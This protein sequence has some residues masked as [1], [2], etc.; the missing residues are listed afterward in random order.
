MNPTELRPWLL[1]FLGPDLSNF[2]DHCLIF[3]DKLFLFLKF[4][5]ISQSIKARESCCKPS[6]E[7]KMHESERMIAGNNTALCVCF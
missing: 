7:Q 3:Q 4:R 5:H 2:T 6:H 1:D